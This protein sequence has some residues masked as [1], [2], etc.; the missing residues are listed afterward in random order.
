MHRQHNRAESAEELHVR[1]CSTTQY[2][3]VLQYYGTL[4][5]Q[6]PAVLCGSAALVCSYAH[7]NTSIDA[8]ALLSRLDLTRVRRWTGRAAQ[9]PPLIR[10]N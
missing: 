7:N 10:P 5:P 8:L 9:L 6:Y 1:L 4:H 2:S 3:T